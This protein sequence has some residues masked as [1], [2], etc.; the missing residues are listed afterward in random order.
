MGPV[1]RAAY[2]L[3][4]SPVAFS[5]WRASIGSVALATLLALL[6]ARGRG[7]LRWR[8]LPPRAIG[9]LVLAAA[10]SLVLNVS[11]FTAFQ[12]TSIA[13]A[14]LAFYTYPAFVATAS[15][16]L[17][18]EKLTRTRAVAL[19]LA[20]AGMVIVVVGGATGGGAADAVGIALALLASVMQ[21][22]YVIL[23]RRGFRAIPS[24]EATFG[25]LGLTAIGYLL[26]AIAA[27]TLDLVA[28]PLTEPSA[29]GPLLWAGVAGAGI[30]TTLFLV[31]VRSIGPTRAATVALLEPVFGT[32][33]AALLL[34]ESLAVVQVA[35]GVLVLAAAALVQRGG[36]NAEPHEPASGAA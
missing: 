3:G 30:P 29:F 15:V 5:F 25:V 9:A 28:I 27:G 32:L 22:A 10:T 13:V 36:E 12:R 4:L 11:I 20:L 18:E 21:A 14:L 24:E 31:G 2:E 7:R 35:G 6:F 8:T 19:G 26:L 33:L 16:A 1:S 34:G 17:G 23:G